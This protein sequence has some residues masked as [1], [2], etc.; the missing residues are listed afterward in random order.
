MRRA[1]PAPEA[2]TARPP[3]DCPIIIK[4]EEP[5]ASA[6]PK[7]SSRFILTGGPGQAESQH[8]IGKRPGDFW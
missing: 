1:E 3:A 4:S 8:Y 5:V 7:L 2:A 6:A